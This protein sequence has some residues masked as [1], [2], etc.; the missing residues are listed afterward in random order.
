MAFHHSR[1]RGRFIASALIVASQTLATML[2]AQTNQGGQPKPSP[3]ELLQQSVHGGQAPQ[4]SVLP[5]SSLPAPPL[6]AATT[7]V[8][9]IPPAPE[10]LQPPP[11]TLRFEANL[12]DV[13]LMVRREQG[14]KAHGPKYDYI[15]T[16]PCDEHLSRDEVGVQRVSLSLQGQTPIDMPA[17]VTLSGKSILR[18]TYDSRASLR[19]GGLVIL[20]AGTV[21]GAV[22]ASAGTAVLPQNT[23]TGVSLISGGSAFSIGSLVVG[24]IL[25]FK[26]D[27]ARIDVV[28]QSDLGAPAGTS[29]LWDRSACT[30]HAEGV[31]VRLRF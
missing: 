21:V 12:D 3:P 26:G 20:V 4:P 10:V 9:V 7:P 18:A 17:P 11:E 19:A 15:C 29:L 6:R 13:R 23:G 27:R 16:A 2:F 5:P 30:A 8:P 22:I 25:S 31:A 24:L 28:P 1:Y 14:S